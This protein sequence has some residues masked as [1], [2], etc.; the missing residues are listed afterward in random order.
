MIKSYAI[1]ADFERQDALYFVSLNHG[2]QQVGYGVTAI[3]RCPADEV[4]YGEKRAEVIG[5]MSPFG[6]EPGV[7]EIQ[8][9][10]KRAD[11]ERGG[12]RVQFELRTRDA[13]A[14]RHDGSWHGGAEQF[15]ACRIIQ[16]Q[17]AAAEGVQKT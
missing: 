7:V 16:R 9:A 5:G 12:H 14:V 10:D 17:Q 13:A 6:C 3:R 1:E 8:P 11:V 4:G 2:G 15:C